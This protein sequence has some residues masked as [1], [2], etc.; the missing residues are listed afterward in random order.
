MTKC[1]KEAKDNQDLMI[2]ETFSDLQ[3][4]F[5]YSDRSAKLKRMDSQKE[6]LTCK[7]IHSKY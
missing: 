3:A 6:E 4:E 2:R 1:Y 5:Q 7:V